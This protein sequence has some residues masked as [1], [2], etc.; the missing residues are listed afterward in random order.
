[1]L[2]LKCRNRVKQFLVRRFMLY[3]IMNYQW[4]KIERKFVKGN[5]IRLPKEF[6]G[7]FKPIVPIKIRKLYFREYLR[8]QRIQYFK[9]KDI[10]DATVIQLNIDHHKQLAKINSLNVLTNQPIV[11]PEF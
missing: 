3:A 6:K 5:I 11:R 1:M 9:Q 7:V 2:Y 4:T 10:Y 8:W